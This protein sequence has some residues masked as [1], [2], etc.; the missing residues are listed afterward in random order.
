MDLVKKFV[1]YNGARMVEGWPERIEQAQ[2]EMLVMIGGIEY[3]R[4]RYGNEE[5]DWGADKH[6]CH[7]CAV[8]KGQFHVPGCDVERCPA[9]GGQAIGCDCEY[10]GDEDEDDA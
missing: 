3:E 6:P 5:D 2:T 1:I 4:V 8:I 9:C 10:E 7:D